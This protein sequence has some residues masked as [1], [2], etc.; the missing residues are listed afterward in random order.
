M[1]SAKV[2]A[3]AWLASSPVTG[4]W[5]SKLVAAVLATPPIRRATDFDIGFSPHVFYVIMDINLY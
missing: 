2:A 5:R 1:A 3:A 4:S